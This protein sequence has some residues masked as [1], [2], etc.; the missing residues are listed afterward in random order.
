M[1][2]VLKIDAS[3][4]NGI[5]GA[6]VIFAAEGVSSPHHPYVRRP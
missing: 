3:A 6:V 1:L 2:R 4:V 5:A